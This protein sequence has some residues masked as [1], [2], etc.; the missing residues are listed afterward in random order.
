MT[1]NHILSH[2]P[3]QPGSIASTLETIEQRIK[4]RGDLPHVTVSRQLEL[5]DELT[6]FSFGRFLLINKG[7][8]GYWTH[9]MVMHPKTGRVTGINNEGKPFTSLERFLLDQAPTVLAT[10]QRFVNFQ[11]VLHNEIRSNQRIASIPCGLMGDLFTLNYFHVDDVTLVGIDLDQDSLIAAKELAKK[12]DLNDRIEFDLK[13]A[14]KLSITETYD[15]ITSNGLNIYE[16][17][18]RKVIELYK[19]F[20][21]ALN[22]EGILI[23][24]FVTPP[25]ND[26]NQIE[27]WD[28]SKINSDHL[29]LQKVIFSDIIQAQWQRFRTA[30]QTE[31]QLIDAGFSQ[32]EFI[33][34]D[35]GMFPT[36]VARK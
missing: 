31:K 19:Q 16:P 14:W 2:Q 7:I 36:V 12:H 32:I 24:S 26:K 1:R 6:R 34:D 20:H 15:I 3:D 35:A 13:D 22:P 5:L 10:Q 8:N 33:I 25:P 23:T 4:N 21:Q 28:L 9:Y 18:D 27:T 11:T 29:R 17:D 30:E